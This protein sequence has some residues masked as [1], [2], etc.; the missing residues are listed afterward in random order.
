MDRMGNQFLAGPRFAAN[1]HGRAGRG[2]LGDLFVDLA[3]AAT[4]ANDV[5]KIIALPQFL[6][7]MLVLIAETLPLGLDEVMDIDRLGN[8]GGHHMQEF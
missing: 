3:H 2:Y 7:Q 8:H 4:V 6:A 5:G 1:E